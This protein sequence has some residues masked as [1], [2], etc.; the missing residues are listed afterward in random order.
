MEFD[1]ELM[2]LDACT[3]SSGAVVTLNNE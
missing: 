3:D 2:L 1:E